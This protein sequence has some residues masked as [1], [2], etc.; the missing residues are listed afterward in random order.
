MQVFIKFKTKGVKELIEK[1]VARIEQ[2][3]L[4][5]LQLIGEKFVKD[6]RSEASKWKY[7]EQGFEKGKISNQQKIYYR[8]GKRYTRTPG[9]GES[10]SDWTG[11][12]RSSIGF[13]ILKNGEVV[14]QAFDGEKNEGKQAGISIANEISKDFPKGFVLIVV[15]GMNYA[16]YAES[17]GFDVITSSALIAEDALREAIK[18]LPKEI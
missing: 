6:A 17:H 12:L 18:N 8:N 9:G 11:N 14:Q 2:A 7:I 4:F 15:S 10:F 5:R 13:V 1:R 16:A 3:I